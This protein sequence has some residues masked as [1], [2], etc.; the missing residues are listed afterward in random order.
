[1][2]TRTTEPKAQ[3]PHMPDYGIAKGQKGMLSWDWVDE[4]MS[5][6]RNYWICST[7]PDGRP[8]AAPVWGVWMDNTLYFSSSRK[9]QKGRNLAASPEVA[10]HLDSGDDV[11]MLEGRVEEVTDKA[12]LARMV[13]VYGAKYEF[14]PNPEGEPGNVYYAVKP[15]LAFAWHEKNFP[16]SATRWKFG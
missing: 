7:K 6:A 1:M 9:S 8:H 5:Q 2:S 3:R 15:R 10:I 14:K 13:E 12:V 16:Q 4:Q 11:V